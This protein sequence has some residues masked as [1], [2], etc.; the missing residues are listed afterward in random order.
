MIKIIYCNN[1]LCTINIIVSLGYNNFAMSNGIVISK[2]LTETNAGIIVKTLIKQG[3]DS[4][5]GYPGAAVL[6][7]YNELSQGTDVHQGP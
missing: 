4:I 5:F 6:S 7:I 3:V 1:F 2:K